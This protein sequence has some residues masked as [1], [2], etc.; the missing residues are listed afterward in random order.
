ML[1]LLRKPVAQVICGLLC[2]T[3]SAR[4][5]EITVQNDSFVSGGP[6]VIVGDFVPGEEAGARL[7][8]PCNG[9]IVA[10]QIGWL[11]SGGASPTIEQAIHIYNGA[12]FPTPGA[13]LALLEAPLMTPGALNEFRY[14]DEQ[15]SIP[16]SVPVT[17]G[18]QF[19]V[20]LEF[21][22]AT[23]VLGGSASVFRD[24]NG[25]QPGKNVL[26]AIPGG[27]LNFCIFLTGDLVIRAVIDCP[28]ATGACCLPSGTCSDAQTLQQCQAQAGTYQGDNSNCS[29][30]NCP[31]PTGACCINGVCSSQTQAN[32]IAQGGTFIGV[33][34]ICGG[35]TCRGACCI[36]A[37]EQCAFVTEPVCA[38]G[39]GVFQG[40][41][42][43]CNSIVCFPIGACCLPDGACADGQS[44]EECEALRGTFQGDQTTCAGAS[45]PVPEGACCQGSNCFGP[46]SQT[47]C[48]LAFGGAWQGPNSICGAPDECGDS[49]PADIAPG[50]GDGLVN[51]ADLLFVISNWGPCGACAADV[52]PQPNGDGVVNVNDLLF[53][54]SNWGPCG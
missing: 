52:A 2:M 4:A 48:E 9:T 11:S 45:C 23:D 6:A 30:V 47:D 38:G 50:N 43:E 49:C 22:N 7:T 14:L 3:N 15:Q 53:V 42:V 51:V 32:C 16:L 33:G 1:T 19:Y 24:V 46:L 36:A 39:G 31:Q 40:I 28:A 37:T 21:A 29:G 27:W 8:S 41:G 10:V 5:V 17:A 35:N 54:I 34:L 44:P 25:C 20:T 18:Q 12:T 13:Q 26:F